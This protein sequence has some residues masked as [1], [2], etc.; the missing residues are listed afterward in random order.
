MKYRNLVFATCFAGVMVSG[1]Q[2][3]ITQAGQLIT[4]DEWQKIAAEAL[5]DGDIIVFVDGTKQC[6]KAL[7]LPP[8]NYSFGSLNF[9]PEEVAVVAFKASD[10]VLKGQYITHG[11]QQY[12]GTVNADIQFAPF[13]KPTEGSETVETQ[14]SGSIHP[15]AIQLLILHRDKNTKYTLSKRLHHLELANGDI[16]PVIFEKENILLSSGWQDNK[17]A[18]QEIV[19]ITVDGGIYGT[20][21]KNGRQQEL[22]FTFVKEKTVGLQIP[23]TGETLR[24]P[25]EQIN[26]IK[27][28][29]GE[30]STILKNLKREGQPFD[31]YAFYDEKRPIVYDNLYAAIDRAIDSYA[32]EEDTEEADDNALNHEQPLQTEDVNSSEEIP[33]TFELP[34]TN[35][36]RAPDTKSEEDSFDDELSSS[37]RAARLLK[38]VNAVLSNTTNYLP[39]TEE[40]P[41]P[42]SLPINNDED[43]EDESYISEEELQHS[44]RELLTNA[45][46]LREPPYEQ[47]QSEESENRSALEKIT[48]LG[49]HSR[50][51]TVNSL[52]LAFTELTG[53]VKE[54]AVVEALKPR[55]TIDEI[56]ELLAQAESV[57]KNPIEQSTDDNLQTDVLHLKDKPAEED[58][59][60]I[61]GWDEYAEPETSEEMHTPFDSELLAIQFE[62]VQPPAPN[63]EKGTNTDSDSDE[64]EQ[65]KSLLSVAA[66]WKETIDLNNLTYSGLST[67]GVQRILS[68]HVGQEKGKDTASQSGHWKEAFEQWAASQNNDTKAWRW[69]QLLQV[70]LNQRQKQAEESALRT[71]A[72][73]EINED[74]IE[75]NLEREENLNRIIHNELLNDL[76]D[77]NEVHFAVEEQEEPAEKISDSIFNIQNQPEPSESNVNEVRFAAEDET[78][79]EPAPEGFYQA[80]ETDFV[81]FNYEQDP[82]DAKLFT[83]EQAHL[84]PHASDQEPFTFLA[85]GVH[86][87]DIPVAF[88]ETPKEIALAEGFIALPQGEIFSQ[89]NSAEKQTHLATIEYEVPDVDPAPTD[90]RIAPPKDGTEKQNRLEEEIYP[91]D[92]FVDYKTYPNEEL[93][94]IELD[95]PDTDPTPTDLYIEPAGEQD[96]KTWHNAFTLYQAL[97]L[98]DNSTQSKSDATDPTLNEQFLAA[99][100]LIKETAQES[101]LKWNEQV[102]TIELDIPD[103][104]PAPTDLY[105]EP[106]SE[107]DENIAVQERTEEVNQPGSQSWNNAFKIYQTLVL[108]GEPAQD[109]TDSP[110]P[111]LETYDSPS[112][113]QFQ[114]VAENSTEQKALFSG[115]SSNQELALLQ[116]TIAYSNEPLA[117]YPQPSPKQSEQD[118]IWVHS[119]EA[120]QALIVA[121]KPTAADISDREESVIAEGITIEPEAAEPV[122]SEQENQN[123]EDY[124]ETVIIKSVLDENEPAQPNESV[125]PT[126]DQ[127]EQIHRLGDPYVPRYSS[128]VHMDSP[129]IESRLKNSNT[130]PRS[131]EI[132]FEKQFEVELPPEQPEQPPQPAPEG[133]KQSDAVYAQGDDSEETDEQILL[134]AEQDQEDQVALADEPGNVSVHPYNGTIEAELNEQFLAALDVAKDTAHDAWSKL[135]ATAKSQDEPDNVQLNNDEMI[136]EEQ[137]QNSL[138]LDMSHE[139][140]EEPEPII[141]EESSAPAAPEGPS[142][143]EKLVAMITLAKEK[144]AEASKQTQNDDSPNNSIDSDE[145]IDEDE[146]VIPV[147]E[148]VVPDQNQKNE[149]QLDMSHELKGEPEPVQTYQE[150][151]IE[152]SD[153]PKANDELIKASEN[154]SDLQLDLD[155]ELKGEPEPIEEAPKQMVNSVKDVRTLKKA[156]GKTAVVYSGVTFK[157]W[158]TGVA[159]KSKKLNPYLKKIQVGAHIWSQLP[160]HEKNRMIF[161]PSDEIVI[162]NEIVPAHSNTTKYLRAKELGQ[163]VAV[164]DFFIDPE[165]VTNAQ[166]AQ[167]IQ[168]THHRYPSHWVNGEI[169]QGAE[170]E[171]VVNITYRDAEA[172]A[173]WA[174]K[175]LPTEIEW[176]RAAVASKQDSRLRNFDEES[177]SNVAEWTSSCYQKDCPPKG[178]VGEE[179]RSP[180]RVIRRGEITEAERKIPI[181]E[182]APMHQ[183]DANPYTGFR[184]VADQ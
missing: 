127:S 136:E 7:M 23:K 58:A 104:D 45:K 57:S 95:I 40:T 96:E 30:F 147:F 46:P 66:K 91:E 97:V 68:R 126:E 144:L 177:K 128:P 22:P 170:E 130:D 99:V 161:V 49:D 112:W 159:A 105:I 169:P 146:I 172:Y 55:N 71:I 156:R 174:G 153:T 70:Y 87:S 151:K 137:D 124:G 176:E 76:A 106:V 47:P 4:P 72:L 168:E 50:K 165:E 54:I 182:R 132:I 121:S 88:E 167:F 110:A 109:K 164:G 145:L 65:F 1:T 162:V 90:L 43:D 119:L 59:E 44:L 19:D 52:E 89:P 67:K 157:D 33:R 85:Q 11:G 140:K 135:N 34:E 3:V 9:K 84:T 134:E 117:E 81:V 138:Q 94:T 21:S 122:K 86:H 16:L 83:N 163:A 56:L 25:W 26:R 51:Q 154:P 173:A 149:L 60:L 29:S 73:Q 63:E 48:A 178:R 93:A 118:S 8:L 113:N 82:H 53:E 179:Q 160:D 35:V 102:A 175:R 181:I 38:K 74:D 115:V 183:D 39:V 155:Y 125:K 10:G 62:E 142:L 20:I 129:T 36:P 80:F 148:E 107:Q 42:S 37:D 14:E 131:S 101:W 158:K 133:Q 17:L 166:Y 111:N 13:A 5:C 171:P 184:C 64:D 139:L 123:K 92:E 120:Y 18:P 75:R 61:E 2:L 143:N 77:A 150:Q 108:N 12:V 100:S 31:Y 141:H 79:P 24:L 180:F 116:H 98:N 32:E 69:E 15:Q 27:A 152:T 114:N 103:T 6:G 78:S 41:Q 28:D